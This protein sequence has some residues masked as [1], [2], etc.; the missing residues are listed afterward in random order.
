MGQKQYYRYITHHL[1]KQKALC[2]EI[3]E[4][5]S[6]TELYNIGSILCTK[7]GLAVCYVTSENAKMHFAQNDDGKG[8]KRGQLTY[9]IAYKPRHRT[10]DLKKRQQRFTDGEILMLTSNY[11]H[12]LRSDNVQTI[13]FNNDF[14]NADL[15]ALHELAVKLHIKDN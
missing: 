5:K 12:W 9:A 8:M 14:F 4:L 13:L 6:G 15:Q 7:D 1:Y 11:K 3:L 2:G 10:S